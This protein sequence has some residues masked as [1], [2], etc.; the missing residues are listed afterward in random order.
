MTLK[1]RLDGALA[2]S[3]GHS[4]GEALFLICTKVPYG[5]GQPCLVVSACYC[6]VMGEPSQLSSRTSTDTTCA[7]NKRMFKTGA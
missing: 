2:Q 7:Q 4:K 1:V 5:S 6:D 3:C